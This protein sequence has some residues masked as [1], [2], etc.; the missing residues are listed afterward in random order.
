M[1]PASEALTFRRVTADDW[2]SIKEIWDDQ[3]R[4]VYACFDKP[5]DTAPEAVRKRIAAWASYA[6]SVEHLFFAV[7]LD[8]HLIGYVAFNRRSNGYETG[9][10]F[11]SRNHG[12][13]Y[14]KKSLTAL[15]HVIHDIYPGAVITA[16][17]ALENTPSVRLLLSLGFRQVGTEQVSFYK[18]S[19]GNSI[20][21]DGGLFEQSGQDAF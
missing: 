16:G 6:D 9:Y 13:G 7:C 3:K 10:C 4:S 14:A 20:Y 11:H 17:T 21:F 19:H 2:E 1:E 15:M 18:D 8:G 5:N 12:K